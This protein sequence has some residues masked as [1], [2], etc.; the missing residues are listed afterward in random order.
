[1]SPPHF[2]FSSQEGWVSVGRFL[3]LRLHIIGFGE[4]PTCTRPPPS[5]HSRKKCGKWN[6]PEIFINLL[7][8]GD[9]MT[10]SILDKIRKAAE[11]RDKAI[12]EQAQKG[13]CAPC[14]EPLES[15]MCDAYE[16][17]AGEE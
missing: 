12:K 2:T 7:P 14:D 13:F 16:A 17:M 10:D 15:C 4:N 11:A 5:H 1:M 9:N 8:F 6:T 3:S